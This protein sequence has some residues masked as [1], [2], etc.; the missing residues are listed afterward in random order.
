M[1]CKSE[2]RIKKNLSFQKA[3]KDEVRPSFQNKFSDFKET[4]HN[5]KK[6]R[7]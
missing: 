4:I 7:D 6:L 2:I 3:Q 5:L 1:G